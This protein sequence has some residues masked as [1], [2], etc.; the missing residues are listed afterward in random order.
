MDEITD[1]LFV[2]SNNGKIAEAK[3]A[4]TSFGFNVEPFQINGKLP[5]IEEIQ[6][7]DLATVA[8]DKLRKAVSMVDLTTENLGVMVEDAGFFI[9]EF[10]GFPGVFSS[11]VYKT[12]GINGVIKS[13]ENVEN[14]GA[15]FKCVIGIY[16]DGNELFFEGVCN[17]V[18]STNIRGENGFGYDPIF[19]PNGG[20][21][22]T[23]SEMKMEEKQ[24]FSH[25]GNALEAV[26]AYFEELKQSPTSNH[27]SES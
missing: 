11:Y 14:R 19:I 6:A 7:S 26:R 4:L 18:V 25:R 16:L 2:T 5:E 12:L 8:S 21:G 10:D 20:D 3:R 23:F 13:L 17:G 1:I 9:E 24:Q 15:K 22:R 27:C